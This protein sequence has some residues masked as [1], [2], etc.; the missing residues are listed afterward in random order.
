MSVLRSGA[1][2]CALVSVIYCAGAVRADVRYI[3]DSF[4]NCT[5]AEGGSWSE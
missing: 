5:T 1:L 2:A 4:R 3:Y